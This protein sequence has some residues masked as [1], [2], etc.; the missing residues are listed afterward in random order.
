MPFKK[1]SKKSVLLRLAIIGPPGS[2]KSVWA[3]ITSRAF[4]GKTAVIDTEKGSIDNYADLFDFDREL[5]LEHEVDEKGEPKRDER[6]KKIIEI[7]K[8]YGVD[9]FCGLIS[10]AADA[11]YDNL[12]IDSLSHAW[13]GKGGILDEADEAAAKM[14]TYNTY[15]AWKKATPMHE[16]LVNTILNY[17]GHI[18]CT[19]RSKIAHEQQK[20]EKTGKSKIVKLGMAP[21]Q[22]DTVEYEFQ[23]VGECDYEHNMVITKSRVWTLTDQVLK[24][25]SS[26]LTATGH[27]FTVP[28]MDWVN[29]DKVPEVPLDPALKIN[30]PPKQKPFEKANEMETLRNRIIAGAKLVYLDKDGKY[31]KPH[32]DAALNK[33][34]E[35]AKVEDCKDKEVLTAFIDHMM[36]KLKDDKKEEEAA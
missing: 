21:I 24:P 34:C 36:Q 18:I 9:R 28:Y 12:I 15:A 22:R 25:A 16:L 32:F 31:C 10:N 3:L 26:I 14:R 1:A 27:G 19:I 29:T 5:M 20:D 2:G 33:Y 30:K 23:I 11:G 4:G 8:P 35:V 6:T 7:P 13:V 17:P